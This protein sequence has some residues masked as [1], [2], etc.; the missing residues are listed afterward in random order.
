MAEE[1]LGDSDDFDRPF[2]DAGEPSREPIEFLIVGTREGV[3]A[4]IR[5]FY[6][7]GFAQPDEW[8]RLTPVPNSDRVMTILVRYRKRGSTDSSSR[9][10]G[11]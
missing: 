9:K 8:S 5:N 6:A 4:E 11:R 3:M 7:Q 2:S 10:S 1:F